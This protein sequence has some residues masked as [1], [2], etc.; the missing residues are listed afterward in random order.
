MPEDL[1][2]KLEMTAP[3]AE[4]F[5]E[6]EKQEPVLEQRWHTFLGQVDL[7]VKRLNGL[8][9]AFEDVWRDMVLY[10]V[11]GN[12]E[13]VQAVRPELLRIFERCLGVLRRAHA[14]VGRLRKSHSNE[15]VPEPSVLLP[16]IAG[17][18]RL[19]VS[20]FDR[21]QTAA[22]LEDLAARDYP[23]TTADLD[24]IGPQRRPP[25]SYYAE[26]SKPF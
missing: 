1:L 24:Q 2:L 20:V 13:E 25:A 23:L 18:E 15:A 11:K 17:M 12:T 8:A 26:E 10:V 14:L 6:L 3:V 9:H 21:W 5:E 19:K 22:D 16:E 4:D 7:G